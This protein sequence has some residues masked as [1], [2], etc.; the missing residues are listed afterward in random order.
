MKGKSVCPCWPFQSSVMFAEA[1]FLVMYDP[2]M[3]EL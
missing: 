1:V 3:N 2:S